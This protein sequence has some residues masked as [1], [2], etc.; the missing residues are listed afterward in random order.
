M[1]KCASLTSASPSKNEAMAVE[2]HAC[3]LTRVDTTLCVSATASTWLT[4]NQKMESLRGGRH[5]SP[6][7]SFRLAL[8]IL[9]W[10]RLLVLS[11]VWFIPS[12]PVFFL[13]AALG[14][15]SPP[16]PF[17][18]EA[19]SGWA[20]CF[21]L[22]QSLRPVVPLFLLLRD[23]IRVDGQEEQ[24]RFLPI[25]ISPSILNSPPVLHRNV[26]KPFELKMT[27]NAKRTPNPFW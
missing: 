12:L 3:L 15:L 9:C 27:I 10:R 11:V 5:E 26:N 1:E 13:L 17:S 23:A 22:A 14:S 6:S 4:P 21:S 25:Q 16:V 7:L 18:A 20:F 2:V 24:P 8:P 19:G